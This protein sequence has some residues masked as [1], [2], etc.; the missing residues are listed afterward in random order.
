MFILFLL[1]QVYVDLL[2]FVALVRFTVLSNT[3]RMN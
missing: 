1:L 2:G 3:I